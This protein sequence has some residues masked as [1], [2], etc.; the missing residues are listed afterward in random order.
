MNHEKILEN[1]IIEMKTLLE[2]SI[3][4]CIVGG[5]K[6]SNGLL[7]K[8]SLIRSK[9]LINMLHEAVKH[10]LVSE[11]IYKENLVPP[12][13]QTKPELKVSGFL[14]KKDQDVCVIPL[15]VPKVRTPITWGPLAYEGEIDPLGLEFTEKTLIINVRSQ[16]S[17][18]AKNADTLFERTFAETTNLHTIYP[19]AV[20]GEVYLIPVYEYHAEAAKSNSVE[21]VQKPTNLEKYISFFTSISNR[22]NPE[23]DIYKYERCALIIVDFSSQTPKIYKNTAELKKD[24]LISQGFDLELEDISYHT[25]FENILSIYAER[26]NPSNIME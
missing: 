6:K 5:V 8:E 9:T 24:G 18:L 13:H 4:T 7:A 25:F 2:N 22:R 17:S 23:T 14:K 19:N 15:N 26:F 11:G 16:L 1:T 3:T 21:F 12:L 20:L 10:S